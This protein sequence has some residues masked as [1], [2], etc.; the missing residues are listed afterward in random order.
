MGF[1]AV[2]DVRSAILGEPLVV[3]HVG[4]DSLRNY[5]VRVDPFTLLRGGSRILYPVLVRRETRSSI[6][7]ARDRSGWKGVAYGGPVTARR[8]WAVLSD[9][10]RR[11][12]PS[13]RQYFLVQVLALNLNFLGVNQNGNLGVIP[14]LDD[15][16]HKLQAGVLLPAAQLFALLVPDA[17]GLNDS[18]PH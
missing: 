13:S 7:L 17:R 15:P 18:V 4:L 10:T 2:S 16:R 6:T 12:P 14:L 8:V 1:D 3:F 9:T 5:Q 11:P